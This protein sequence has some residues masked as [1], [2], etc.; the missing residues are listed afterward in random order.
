MDDAALESA[1]KAKYPGAYDDLSEP[2]QADPYA[3]PKNY[4]Q[5]SRED[6]IA[7]HMSDPFT[8]GAASGGLTTG[9]LTPI[10]GL[11]K[12]GAKFV[13]GKALGSQTP[14]QRAFPNVDLADEALRYGTNAKKVEGLGRQSAKAVVDAGRSSPAAP[15]RPSEIIAGLRP[16]FDRAAQAERGGIPGAR[17]RVLNVARDIRRQ[18]PRSGAS[19]EDALVAKSEWQRLA[20]EAAR[21]AP[22]ELKGPDS[23]V[24]K[25]VGDQFT[26]TIRGRGD[27]TLNSALD[28]SQALM[29]LQRATQN[30]SYRPS[31]LQ[32]ILGG[33][34]GGATAAMTGDWKKAAAATMVPMAMSPQGLSMM[35]RGIN[36]SEPAISPALEAIY[37]ALMVAGSPD[38][39]EQR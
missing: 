34:T 36:A 29:A 35:A 9:A 5:M 23:R 38:G 13:M 33:T 6:K 12:E 4:G 20:K 28:R 11:V 37:R 1:V 39:Q 27:D 17:Q 18:M 24:A 10:K 14:V 7:W 15:I 32:M 25:A 19:I 8:S 21:A 31:L 26:R 16:A 3:K 30:M 2:E 22:G